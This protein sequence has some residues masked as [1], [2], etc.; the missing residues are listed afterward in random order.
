MTPA[1]ESWQRDG[2]SLTWQGS[3]VFYK[4]VGHGPPLLL[5]HGYPVGSYDWHAVWPMLAER[6]TLIAPDMLGHGFSGKPLDG[7]YTISSHAKMH[8]ALLRHLGISNCHAV[9]FDLGVSV[10]QEML[11]QRDEGR[12]MVEL[13]SLVLLN[14]GVCPDAYHPRWIQ[15]LMLTRVGPWLGPRIPKQMFQR[16]IASLYEG[17]QAPPSQQL[18]DDFWC[19]FGAG[20]GRKVAHRV[21][22]F[23]HERKAQSSRL[24]EGLL[25]SHIP[26]LM[27]NG[28]ADPNSGAHMVRA[29]LDLA[30]SVPVVSLPSAGH[31][32]QIQSPCLVA[33]A[34]IRFLEPPA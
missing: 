11:A 17:S 2:R 15:K 4:T 25:N 20:D 21:G 33:E 26:L 29:F 32:P 24:L 8:A 1:V 6:F 28:G 5:I 14:G 7:D 9:A 34:I 18:L 16:T 10:A 12:D 19:L 23:W 27:V 13:T 31:W 3:R 22:A 30:P